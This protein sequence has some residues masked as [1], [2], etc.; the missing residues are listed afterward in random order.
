MLSK[1]RNTSHALNTYVVV[2][3]FQALMTHGME[4]IIDKG[5]CAYSMYSIQAICPTIS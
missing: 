2:A 3:H 4:S 5:T 1:V